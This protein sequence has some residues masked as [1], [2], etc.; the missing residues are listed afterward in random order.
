MNESLVER[1]RRACHG[2]GGWRNIEALF[3]EAADAL[4]AAVTW[5]PIETFKDDQ[6]DDVVILRPH[7][8]WGA[9]DVKRNRHLVSTDGT[10]YP[11]VNGDCT[12]MWP[13]EAFLPFW[14]PRPTQPSKET[15][16]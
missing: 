4:E 9:M 14:M 12:N 7:R 13:E 10:A 2:A 16:C 1:L 8:I 11:W 15:A 6:L 3:R 5:Q